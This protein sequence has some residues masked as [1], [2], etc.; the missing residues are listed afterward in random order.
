MITQ[1]NHLNHKSTVSLRQFFWAPW[2][3]YNFRNKTLTFLRSILFLKGETS[4]FPK[5]WTLE[6]KI[7]KLAGCIQ[8]WIISSLND[9]LCFNNLKSNQRS[10]YNLPNSAFW[11]WLSIGLSME[12]QPQ[13]PE[14]RIDP[15][16]FHLCFSLSRQMH[17]RRKPVYCQK[18]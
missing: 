14:F 17:M 5:S 10:H 9:K 11:G 6:I 7:L 13:N 1:K 15:E 3:C 8:K 18:A 2:T 4:K 12:S 16:N